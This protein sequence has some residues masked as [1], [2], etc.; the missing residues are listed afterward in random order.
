M[1][2]KITLVVKDKNYTTSKYHFWKT[3][4]KKYDFQTLK[5]YLKK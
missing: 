1:F 2:N 5:Q 3:L 4:D